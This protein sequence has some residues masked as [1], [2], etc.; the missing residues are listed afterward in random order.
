M[1]GITRLTPLEKAERDKKLRIEELQTLLTQE[2]E[3]RAK[4]L[5]TSEGLRD[6]LESLVKS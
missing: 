2:T 4:S 3:R 5:I 1:F 6:E